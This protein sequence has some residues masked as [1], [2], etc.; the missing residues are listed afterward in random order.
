MP[1]PAFGAIAAQVLGV[2]IATLDIINEVAAY[3]G[4]DAEVRALAQRRVR[5]GN[6]ANSLVVLAQLGHRCRWVGTLGDDPAADLI[7]ADLACYGVATGDAVRI[8]GGATPTSYI[9]L[10][11]AT[12][13]RTI[14][15]FRDLPELDAAAFAGCALEGVG[16]VHFEGRH[17]PETR[18]MIDR[19]RAECP[20]VPVSLELEK[21]RPGI[22]ALL[23]GPQVLL[24]SR[25]FAAAS[26]FTDPAAF[27]ADLAAR[28]SASLCVVAWGEQGA[29]CLVRGGAVQQVPAHRPA[30]V[31]DTLGAG[32]VFNAGVID[33]LARGLAPAE[34]VAAAV[35]LAGEQCGRIGLTLE[36]E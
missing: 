2:G 8:A 25:A 16:W 21:V 3:P 9:A 13:S 31:V 35:R 5:G 14:V 34:A 15:H 4:E 28:T 33:A 6:V 24:A 20:T 22:E 1:A 7:L 26:G 29:S 30:R 11:R 19:V 12:A 32:D 27:L 36:V 17:P 18:R 23:D 10:S